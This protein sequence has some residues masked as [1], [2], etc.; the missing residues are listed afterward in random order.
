MFQLQLFF[1]SIVTNGTALQLC[2]D[3]SLS[4]E[5]HYCSQGSYSVTN[6]LRSRKNIPVRLCFHQHALKYEG[7]WVGER[8]YFFKYFQLVSTRTHS[9]FNSACSKMAKKYFRVGTKNL[10]RQGQWK[11]MQVFFAL[12]QLKYMQV[13]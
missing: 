5:L 12:Q 3:T 8:F 9:D 2:R 4:Q 1:C 13:Y 10:S 7:R 11:F 6:K